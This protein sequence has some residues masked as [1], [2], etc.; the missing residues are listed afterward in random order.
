MFRKMILSIAAVLLISGVLFA[1]S[2]EYKSS[3]KEVT[4]TIPAASVVKIT[5]YEITG[6]PI[7]TLVEEYKQAGDYKI[8]IA[9]ENL[10]T[11]LYYLGIE[12]GEYRE[13]KQLNLQE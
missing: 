1:Q 4:Y 13:F 10:S 8:S 2:A 9:E 7:K 11:G 3:D 12:A 5:V 6:K